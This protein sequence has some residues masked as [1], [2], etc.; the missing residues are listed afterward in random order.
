MSKKQQQIYTNFTLS[1]KFR[2]M[3]RY[4]GTTFP[5][6]EGPVDDR[7]QPGEREGHE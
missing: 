7:L 4:W 6:W 3:T 1:D 5:Y 2:S